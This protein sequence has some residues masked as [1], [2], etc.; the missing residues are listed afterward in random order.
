MA[1]ETIDTYWL[2]EPLPHMPNVTGRTALVHRLYRRLNTQRGRFPWWPNDGLDVQDFLLS[3]MPDTFIANAISTEAEKDEE[4]ATATV[5]VS[6]LGAELTVN[7]EIEDVDGDQLKFTLSVT[8]ARVALL[9]APD[10][11]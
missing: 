4:V 2:D 5:T 1:L 6:R 11:G 9:G 10:A 8:D 3:K 7:I